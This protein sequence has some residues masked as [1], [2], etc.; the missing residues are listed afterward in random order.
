MPNSNAALLL[1][2]VGACS[3]RGVAATT[4]ADSLSAKIDAIFAR[5]NQPDSPGAVC[6]VIRD[7]QLVHV[8]GYGME[9]LE[10]STPL[11]PQS[12][13]YIASTSK[14]FT[15][16][17]IAL[18]SL[19]GK[20]SLDDDI[21]RHLPEMAEMTKPITVR[22]LVHH[23]S[24]LK[25]YFDLL[26]LIGWTDTDYFNNALVVRLLAR[27][28][29]LNF[30]P[31][32]RQLYS[33]SNYVLLAEIVQ[34]VAGQSLRVFA[35]E[36]IFKPLGMRHTHF[37]DDYRQIVPHRVVSYLPKSEGGWHQ[38]LKEFDGYGD[39]NLL[40][41]VEDLA[42]WDENFVTGKVGGAPFLELMYKRGVLASGR[43]IDYAFGLSHLRYRG[44]PTIQHAGGFK[45]FRTEM[46]RFPQQKCTIIVLANAASFN[47]TDTAQRVADVV[48]GD[49]LPAPAPMRTAAAVVEKRQP[50]K[51]EGRVFDD[52]VGTF[53]FN[54]RQGFMLALSRDG[55]RFYAQATGQPR[56]EIFPSS[57]QTFYYTVVDA[58]LT[59]HREP[60]G[61]VQRLT[62]HQ[63]GNHEARR[64]VPL[65]S[66]PTE[67]AGYA[68][69]YTSRELDTTY[70]LAVE[71][72]E[73]VASHVRAPSTILK[74]QGRDRFTTGRSTVEFIRDEQ[75]AIRALSVSSGRAQNVRFDRDPPRI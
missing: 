21:R 68:G 41:T 43:E 34:R 18:L 32:T 55:D 49:A 30:E 75:G 59:F 27:Q 20:L 66:S 19:D 6:A 67:L 51:I 7:G 73:L 53:E 36:R 54:E 25:D 8:R 14:Q 28:R 69:S 65:V 2:L 48:L 16:A 71:K 29:S 26:A 50:A 3:V 9:D 17:S 37:D 42:R 46:I 45:G 74:P 38:L 58:A 35:D 64:T 4:D 70:T 1:T 22:H 11:S 60:D 56:V 10:H 31:G 57:P 33:N 44:A 23:T 15:A 39:G 52:Y 40:T 72:D 24:G 61:S 12:V 13:F 62:L 5:W 47:A 63:G